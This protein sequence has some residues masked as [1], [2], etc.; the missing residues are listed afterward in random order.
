VPYD[1]LLRWEDE[2][3]ATPDAVATPR[4]TGAGSGAAKANE[5]AC[6]L[7]LSN[8]G[9]SKWARRPRELFSEGHMVMAG[10]V[11]A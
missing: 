1:P 10:S 3:G 9:E 11:R 5:A 8:G 2:G 6:P 7:H 4:K